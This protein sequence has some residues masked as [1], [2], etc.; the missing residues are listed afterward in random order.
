MKSTKILL[1]IVILFVMQSCCKDTKEVCSVDISN[2]LT[3]IEKEYSCENT[4]TNM[5]LNSN[6]EYK[7]IANSVD[8]DNLVVGVCHPTINFTK[9][10]LII[11]TI[12]SD[13]GINY[14][15]YKFYSSC[16]PNYYKLSVNY[17]IILSQTGNTFYTY[18]V[19][20]PKEFIID[21]LKITYLVN[22]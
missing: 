18:H 19:L 10:N 2:S 7:V 16:E 14:L 21:N 3:S 15:P 11:G 6:I 20:V 4:T 9:Y 1:I 17:K 5:H 13:V 22:S 12:F 8:Y